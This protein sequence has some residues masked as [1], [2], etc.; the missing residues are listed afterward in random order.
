MLHALDQTELPE[1]EVWLELRTPEEV[2]AAIKR[3]A[4]LV[5]ALVTE[6]GVVRRPARGDTPGAR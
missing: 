6:E 5:S 2:A 1:R 4:I 3:L